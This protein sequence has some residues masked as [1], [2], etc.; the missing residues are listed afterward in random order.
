MK[1]LK[2]NKMAETIAKKD[3]SGKDE[4]LSQIPTHLV[5]ETIDGIPFYYRGFRSVLDKTRKLEDI[6]P[7][8]GLQTFIKNLL[9]LLLAAQLGKDYYIFVGEV[10]SHIDKKNN[11]GLDLTIYDKSVLT[12]DKIT[13]KFIDVPP[14]IVIE[15]D[16]NVELPDKDPNLFEEFV[17]RKVRR[18]HSF[19]VE[20]VIWIFTKSKTVITALPDDNWIVVNWNKEVEVL[21]EVSFNIARLLQEN[22]LDLEG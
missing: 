22:G 18:L 5:K 20:K 4:M 7:E 11:L 9:H 17:L 15:I 8:S 13:T 16:V 6:M 3:L 12:P 19:G 1:I 2:K 10:G 14:K 21:N